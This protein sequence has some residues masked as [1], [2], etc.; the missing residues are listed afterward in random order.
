MNPKMP[1]AGTQ[2]TVRWGGRA[3]TPRRNGNTWV[4]DDVAIDLLTEDESL[5][6][7][8]R[9]ASELPEDLTIILGLPSGQLAG[10]RQFPL[11][12][13]TVGKGGGP[14]RLGYVHAGAI[15]E[16]AARL[17]LPMVVGEGW[18]L[19]GDPLFSTLFYGDCIEWTYPKEVGLENGEE[20]R[21]FKVLSHAADFDEAVHAYYREMVPEIAPGPEWLH[22]IAMVSYDYMSKGGR[23]WYQDIDALCERLPREDRAQ[24]AL[25]LHAWFDW[26]GGYCYDP[27]SGTLLDEWTNF[28]S[29]EKFAGNA[30]FRGIMRT[31]LTRA[32]IHER[33]A[34]ARSRGFRVCFYFADGMLM[35]DQLPHF[36][37]HWSLRKEGYNWSGPDS[38]GANHPLNPLV[39]EVRAFFSGYL[40]ALLAEYGTEIDALVWDETFYIPAGVRSVAPYRGYPGRAMLTLVRDLTQRVQ[41][42]NRDHTTTVAFLTSDALGLDAVAADNPTAIY[43]HGTFQ[44][45]ACA[46][47]TWAAGIYSNYRNVVWS[48]LWEPTELW[49]RSF[50]GV[51]EH[52]APVPISNGYAEDIG[53]AKLSTEWQDKILELF[54]W[55]KRNRTRLKPLPAPEVIPDYALVQLGQTAA[56]YVP[57]LTT[58]EKNG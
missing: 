10:D 20:R 9:S 53:F 36:Q 27:A 28:G 4:I 43:A 24:V 37:P 44:D 22:E 34:Y 46:A 13:G 30:I 57:Q 2:V 7:A 45:T 17:A 54:H 12:D 26:V 23:G 49:G 40:D 35:G 31:R 39:P 29:V 3:I 55:R 41:N 8:V 58:A 32:D 19:M 56:Q 48:C 18:T 25:T 6:V 16:Y 51:H 52:Q 14:E 38:C 33:I 5:C 21:T 50:Y 42:F 15:G 1:F 11:T 47:C